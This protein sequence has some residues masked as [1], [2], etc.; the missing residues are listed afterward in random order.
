MFQDVLCLCQVCFVSVIGHFQV[1]FCVCV[2]TKPFVQKCVS[3]RGSFSCKSNLFLCEKV[4]TKTCFETE[5]QGNFQIAFRGLARQPCCM[6]GTMKMFCIRE[7]IFSHRKKNLLFLPCNMTAVQNHYWLGMA[8]VVRE[9]NK[10]IHWWKYQSRSIMGQLFTHQ[11]M[12]HVVMYRS[13]L[14][15]PPLPCL[16]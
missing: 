3:P 2:K 6:A 9:G 7:N 11:G 8:L 5:V 10:L 13:D 1:L 14:L 15:P 16:P 4:C 12:E